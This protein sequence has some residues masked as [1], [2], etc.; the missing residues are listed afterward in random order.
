M[1]NIIG[2][3]DPALVSALYSQM[4]ALRACSGDTCRT[5]DA[6]VPPAPTS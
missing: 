4:Q 5:A 2:S 6:I 1:N 3:A